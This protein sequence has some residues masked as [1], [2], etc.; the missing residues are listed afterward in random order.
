VFDVQLA[1][2]GAAR[3]P[4]ERVAM[5]ARLENAACAARLSTMYDMLE[6]A[7]A[8]SGSADRDSWRCDNWASVCA[9]IG[10]AQTITSG[11]ANGLL[12]NAVIMGEHYPLIGQVFSDGLIS[13]LLVRTICTRTAL[14]KDP[15]ARR[16]LDAELAA[17]LR[18][19]GAKGVDRTIADIDALVLKHDPYAVRRDEETVRTTKVTVHHDKGGGVSYI[20][21]TV[22]A[23][24]G[25]AFDE[26]ADRLA[27]TVCSRDPRTLDQRRAAAVG[28]MGFGWDRLPCLCEHPD[29]DA[30]TI[31]PVGGVVIHVITGPEALQ[32]ES[33]V[34]PPPED[35]GPGPEPP[36]DADTAIDADE[37]SVADE[38]APEPEAPQPDTS[39]PPEPSTSADD[40][41]DDESTATDAYVHNLEVDDDM[42]DSDTVLPP[43]PDPAPEAP[44]PAF[45]GDLDVQRRALV[46]KSKPL[47][48]KPLREYTW[49]E[50][51]AELS[52]D[53]REFSPAR[54]GVILGGPVLPGP[55]IAKL[56]LTAT[57]RALIHPG[58]SPP[59]PRYRPSRALAA[60]IRARDLTCR[61][62]GC[63]R[64]ATRC[65]I[66]HVI[67]YPYGPTA[68]S[69]LACLCVEH[70]LLKTFFPGWSYRLDP[71]GTAHWIDPD[72]HSTTSH[73]GSRLIFPELCTPTAQSAIRGTPPPK[74]T[75]G[76]TTPKRTRTRAENRARRI[77]DERQ[78][79]IND[80]QQR[81][82]DIPPPF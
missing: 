54:P 42:D 6:H 50:L 26:R 57:L 30:A 28:A 8:A 24:D 77:D 20:D 78:R 49:A 40:M 12:T 37:D 33:D 51:L 64:P 11:L 31:P 45:L 38:S 10:A 43:E 44:E 3:T 36:P 17:A 22:D 63:N 59:E 62:P 67:P 68:A 21:A 27:R 70:H 46:G 5:Q 81:E 32:R 73:P 23:C 13:Y 53:P 39:P 48:S 66:D 16:A 35:P 14:V 58:Q 80:A 75:A 71:D 60:F 9:Q 29:C 56:A 82:P 41:I 34:P 19:W 1:A 47:L 74:H 7:Y 76:L 61:H 79:N 72:G 25:A 15:D 4:A 52:N 2:I 18:G 65:E 69:N 55:V